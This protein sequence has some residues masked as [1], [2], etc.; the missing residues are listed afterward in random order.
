LAA[1]NRLFLT[2]NRPF[3]DALPPSNP[4]VLL[5]TR[6]LLRLMEKIIIRIINKLADSQQVYYEQLSDR[7]SAVA[8]LPW[9]KSPLAA[10]ELTNTATMLLAERQRQGLSLYDIQTATGISRSALSLIESQKNANP[11]IATLE[12]IAEAL[13]KKLLVALVE[14]DGQNTTAAVNRAAT[15]RAGRIGTLSIRPAFGPSDPG[16]VSSTDETRRQ[17]SQDSRGTSRRS[18][19]HRHRRRAR[20]RNVPCCR[21]V[22]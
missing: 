3:L 5:M 22:E 8:S 19:G 2:K 18:T 20:K 21:R 4:K 10:G 7:L 15:R 6:E 17:E 16:L 9:A 13:G 14:G 11:S 1:N 12:R